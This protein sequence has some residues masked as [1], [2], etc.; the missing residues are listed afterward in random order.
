M[1]DMLLQTC[2]SCVNLHDEHSETSLL[3]VY[4]LVPVRSMRWKATPAHLGQQCRCSE[5]VSSLSIRDDRPLAILL[6]CR[7]HPSPQLRHLPL[8]QRAQRDNFHFKAQSRPSCSV[9]KEA[10]YGD[11]LFMYGFGL[12]S[13]RS[14][15]LHHMLVRLWRISMMFRSYRTCDGTIKGNCDHAVY[16]TMRR[17]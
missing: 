3:Q 8:P 15:L 7:N 1:S 9:A 5:A 17:C 6:Q 14:T 2:S 13:I 16:V 12:I 10:I 11:R 4:K